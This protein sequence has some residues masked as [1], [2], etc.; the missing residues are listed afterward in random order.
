M[1]ATITLNWTILGERWGHDRMVSEPDLRPEVCQQGRWAPK[2]W[3]VV[4]HITRRVSGE[5][6]FMEGLH[7]NTI[8]VFFLRA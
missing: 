1:C 7:N 8:K 3:T 5:E 4:F 6:P 2:G